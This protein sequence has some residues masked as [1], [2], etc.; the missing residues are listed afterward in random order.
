MVS[1]SFVG[2]CMRAV[3]VR[4]GRLEPER[5]KYGHA[6]CL[7]YL[8]DAQTTVVDN[9]KAYKMVFNTDKGLKETMNQAAREYT[10]V[11]HNNIWMHFSKWQAKLVKAELSITTLPE[12]AYHFV[13]KFILQH[14]NGAT[15]GPEPHRYTSPSIMSKGVPFTQGDVCRSIIE[16]LRVCMRHIPTLDKKTDDWYGVTRE[17]HIKQN[18]GAFLQAG[19]LM[20]ERML[21]DELRD[22]VKKIHQII[23]QLTF[24]VRAVT[25]GK[26]QTAEFCMYVCNHYPD[27]V[28]VLLDPAE[29]PDKEQVAMQKAI[30]RREKAEEKLA[31]AKTAVEKLEAKMCNDPADI[32]DKEQLAMQKSIKKRELAKEALDTIEKKEKQSS[33]RKSK[34]RKREEEKAC[35]SK[36]IKKQKRGEMSQN[37][38]SLTKD[39]WLSLV[40]VVFTRIFDP[41]PRKKIRKCR[42]V[43]TDGISASW[44]LKTAKDDEDDEDTQKQK[45]KQKK[46]ICMKFSVADCRV[47]HYGSHG[48]DTVFSIGTDTTVIAVDPGHANLISAVRKH[49][50]NQNPDIF[51]TEFEKK[52]G[53][54]KFELKNTTW[55]SQNGDTRYQQKVSTLN[56]KMKMQDVI[57]IL[58]AASSRDINNYDLHISARLRSAPIMMSIMQIKNKRRWK[59]EAYQTEQRAVNKLVA[60]VLDGVTDKENVVVA[61]GDGSFGPTSKGHA[62]APNKKMQMMLARF[63]P[64]VTV[65]ER[66]TSKTV[67]CCKVYGTPLRCNGYKKRATVMQCPKCRCIHSRDTNAALNILN[68]FLHQS[69]TQSSDVPD[70]LKGQPMKE[71]TKQLSVPPVQ[72]MP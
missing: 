37:V 54:S 43:T 19:V 18:V 21:S 12:T 53:L 51:K 65:N 10:T 16:R 35:S 23:P 48:T 29:I 57:N 36:R 26:E 63:I 44:H 49:P 1:Q 28:H 72:E 45:K 61:W 8:Q 9:M 58:A 46:K 56:G 11:L 50:Q 47:G 7:S 4:D 42:V 62:S 32:S 6:E 33:E 69:E 27:L 60:S 34:K 68:V 2:A 3:C 52:M 20:V 15:K 17:T 66:R 40:D 24:K 64:V 70:Y 39:Q 25:F 22:N 41:P 67:S 31:S 5:V 30:K 38:S 13:T 55:R 14:A 59:F 71:H